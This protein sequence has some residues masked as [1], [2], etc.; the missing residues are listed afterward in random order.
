L[1]DEGMSNTQRAGLS[2]DTAKR[3]DILAASDNADVS[4]RARIIV[5]Y[6][7]GAS[8]AQIAGELALSVSGVRHWIKQY[9][10]R[11]LEA[12]GGGV[13]ELPPETPIEKPKR[14]GRP[15]KNLAPVPEP[16]PEIILEVAPDPIP[17]PI[18]EPVALPKRGRPKRTAPPEPVQEELFIPPVIVD[19]IP[20]PIPEPI[21]PPKRGR[22]KRTAP[23][24][25][26]IEVAEIIEAIPVDEPVFEAAPEIIVAPEPIVEPLAEPRGKR[27]GR[28]KKA[29]A[30]PAEAVIVIPEPAPIPEAIAPVITTVRGLVD[31]YG[32][33]V[34]HARHVAD[35][36]YQLFDSTAEIHRLP[37]HER[38]LLEAGAFLHGIADN[39]DPANHHEKARDIILET[40][41]ERFTL[42]ER[43]MIA[44][45]AAFHRK[46]VHA[47]RELA[48][49]QLP[50]PLQEDTLGL[51]AILRIADGLDGSQTQ[52]T[53][54]VDIQL[55][56]PELNIL[57][58]GEHADDDALRAKV[59]ADLWQRQFNQYVI[60]ERAPDADAE[61]PT[62]PIL[63]APP[64]M[65]GTMPDLVLTL[66]P[67]MSAV[68]AIR[69]LALHYADRL[70]R[71]AASVRS[72]EHHKLTA[73][74]REIERLH[75]LVAL[76][77]TTQFES[78]FAGLQEATTEAVTAFVIY[79]RA[80]P[81]ADDPDDP[82]ARTVAA[83]M[84]TWRDAALAR[85]RAIDMDRYAYFI[86]ELRRELV[87]EPANDTGELIATRVGP[88]IW[89]Q[90]AELRDIVERGES[91]SDALTAARRL[92]DYLLYF[93]SL[94]G[95][96][97]VQALDILAPFE[98]YLTAIHT[99]QALLGS[100]GVDAASNVMRQAQEAVLNEFAD[101]LPVIWASVNSVTFRRAVALA[102]ATP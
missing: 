52:T 38:R 40:P 68:R 11:G 61:P 13:P 2:P 69:K 99:V 57:L 17:E 46:K 24:A 71:L 43:S 29:D 78:E 37:D 36:A 67:S 66:D 62:I 91:V 50:I 14:G 70:D 87:A 4:R 56:G 72:G 12:L 23:P 10:E 28:R 79:D 41:L 42:N 32:V 82:N 64:L 76:T 33:N 15:R 83:K 47:E 22:P 8:V 93:R 60:I 58:T 98:N 94:L 18:S 44:L 30:I 45:L 92:Q 97:A 21:A 26:I 81:I 63:T 51:A 34:D 95:S 89:R 96:E 1:K 9:T 65:R 48:F 55:D 35:L 90:L 20:E 25:E 16:P 31:E 73:F 27:G 102:L 84:D 101:G 53:R 59:K 86:G 19:P 75:S 80:M 88:D 85:A 5:A 77:G 39:L 100:L 6:F 7:A 3:L 74:S 54:I 49:A